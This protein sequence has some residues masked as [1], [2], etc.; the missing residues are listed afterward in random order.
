MPIRSS[1]LKWFAGAVSVVVVSCLSQPNQYLPEDPPGQRADASLSGRSGSLA[2]DGGWGGMAGGGAGGLG[3]AGGGSPILDA[4]NQII[5]AEQPA[6]GCD[7]VAEAKSCVGDVL[8]TCDSSLTL[9]ST[10]CAYGCN[11]ERRE[12]NQCKP[13]TRT[14]T[15]TNLLVICRA[16]GTG[17]DT[18]TCQSGC[19]ASAGECQDCQPGLVWCAGDV[20]RECTQSGEPKDRQTCTQGCNASRMA[21]DV[22]RPGSKVCTGNILETCKSDGTGTVSETCSSGCNSAR[23]VCNTCEPGMK[24][25]SESNLRTCRSDGSGWI[26]QACPNGCQAERC[27]ACNPNQGRS[28]DGTSV[29]ECMRDGSGFS[30]TACARGC[31]GGNCCSGNTEAR[32]GSCAS[33]GGSG[34]SCCDIVTPRCNGTFAC[35]DNRCVIPCGPADGQCPSGCNFSRDRDCEKPNGEACGGD[36]E[37][38]NGN[39]TGGVCCNN[40]QNGCGGQ[41]FGNND[42][43]ACGS[44]C[45]TCAT[46]QACSDGRCECP[47]G[48]KLV[49]GQCRRVV[50]PGQ[51]C[52]S[53]DVCSRDGLVCAKNGLCCDNPTCSKFC[54]RVDGHCGNPAGNRCFT[55]GRDDFCVTRKCKSLLRCDV[56]SGFIC[57]P[58]AG[59]VCGEGAELGVCRERLECE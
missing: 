38:E 11:S 34:Q 9:A 31:A 48:Q 59:A 57:Q 21:C 10:S 14:C 8:K 55:E 4:A 22:C 37:C 15:G 16:D 33:C 3:G 19:N 24:M 54:S 29:K 12:C 58:P 43:R 28:C 47:D 20:V 52:Q 1:S 25:C 23:L 50:G 17:T 53:G 26:D 13:N 36:D 40:N 44:S 49:D 46:G 41:C 7:P 27:N 35:E 45:M 32:G 51:A 18:M 30:L 5:D 42:R 56:G 6:G 2:E 39:C